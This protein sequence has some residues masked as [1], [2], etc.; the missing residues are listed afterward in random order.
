MDKK[1]GT[2]CVLSVT[3]HEMQPRAGLLSA[4]PQKRRMADER[5]SQHHEDTCRRTHP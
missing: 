1:F 2:D 3:L 4:I 5:G